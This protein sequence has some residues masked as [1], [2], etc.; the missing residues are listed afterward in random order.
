MQRSDVTAYKLKR[1]DRAA[2]AFMSAR[3]HIREELALRQ[4]TVVT[5]RAENARLR[6]QNAGL[7]DGHPLDQDAVARADGVA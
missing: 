6:G 4:R 3:D 5:L 1:P 2:A 7:V